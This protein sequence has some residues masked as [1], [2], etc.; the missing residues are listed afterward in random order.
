MSATQ[1]ASVLTS[2]EM[3]VIL[4]L[5]AFFLSIFI[6]V[7]SLV[8][9][10]TTTPGTYYSSSDMKSEKTTSSN[11]HGSPTTLPAIEPLLINEEISSLQARCRTLDDKLLV[12]ERDL[13]DTREASLAAR[14]EAMIYQILW[15]RSFSVSKECFAEPLA[16]LEKSD[17]P[18]YDR[19]IRVLR[20]QTELDHMDKE[21]SGKQ[22]EL[23]GPATSA[24]DVT[25]ASP[26][27]PSPVWEIS[28]DP[29]YQ[30]RIAEQKRLVRVNPANRI[31]TPGDTPLDWF[32]RTQAQKAREKELA[33]A[34]AAA[35]ASPT[36]E[37]S[38]G[39]TTAAPEAAILAP[40]ARLPYRR[41]KPTGPMRPNFIPHRDSKPK[42]KTEPKP[43]SQA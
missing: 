40:V 3:L 18:L 14:K 1:Y 2:P 38:A 33:V 13:L 29:V 42:P 25:T 12:H 31:N 8:G 32:N 19:T 39:T 4:V 27:A 20:A 28:Y 17:P 7:Y 10:E 5:S 43:E 26:R 21:L 34:A 23:S 24:P 11:E 6:S 35:T 30:A 22:P 36:L 15:R 16:S 41:P 9:F 37:S